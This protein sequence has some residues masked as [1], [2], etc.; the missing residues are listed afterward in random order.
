[1]LW[2]FT[3]WGI[4]ALLVI[5]VAGSLAT[6]K[7]FRVER[8]IPAPPEAVWEVLLDTA[9]YPEWNPVFVEVDGDYVKGE[10][11]LNKVRD[12]SGAILEMTALVETLE[13]RAELR[14]SGGTPGILTFDHRWLLAPTEGGTRVVQHE[15][16]RGIGLWFWNADW[17]EPAYSSVNEALAE[18][19]QSVMATVPASETGD[20]HEP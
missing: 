6:R 11:V 4:P 7:T 19:V 18:R 8:T 1:M 16:D 5:V 10:R 9:A 12:P 2:S 3:K 20:E 14:Q 15:V 17:I 13:P